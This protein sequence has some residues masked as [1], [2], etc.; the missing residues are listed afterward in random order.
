MPVVE[1]SLRL[2]G[3]SQLRLSDSLI[4]QSAGE[5]LHPLLWYRC[6]GPP[7]FV[8]HGAGVP[9][10]PLLYP[11]W[12]CCDDVTAVWQRGGQQQFIEFGVESPAEFKVLAASEQGLWASVF[13]DLYEDNDTL[14]RDDFIEPA[15]LVGFRFL[16]E[17][18]AEYDLAGHES[19]EQHQAFVRGRGAD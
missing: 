11:L 8:Y 5:Q 18:L 19:F 10:G 7:Y 2:D 14:Q 17:L 3:L 16:D 15:R 1:V 6:L 4:R 9:D 13:I 12:D